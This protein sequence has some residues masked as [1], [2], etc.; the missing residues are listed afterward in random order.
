MRGGL[1]E[2]S[3]LRGSGATPTGPGDPRRIGSFRLLG[4]LGTGGMGR[5]YLGTSAGRYAAVKQVLPALAADNDF[6]RHF[7]YELDNL[8]KLPAGV[9]AR[10]LASDRTAQPP[11]FAPASP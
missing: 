6:L 7:G 8:A 5:V 2:N 11:W 3:Y 9:S 1:E 4:V 10:M